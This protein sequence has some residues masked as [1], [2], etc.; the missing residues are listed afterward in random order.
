MEPYLALSRCRSN[1]ATP[2]RIAG[3]IDS[4]AAC[5]K[6]RIA[7]SRSPLACAARLR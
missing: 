3:L 5:F 1:S 4:F 2:P 6:Y 7:A